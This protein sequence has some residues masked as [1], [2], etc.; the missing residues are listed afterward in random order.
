MTCA[1][2]LKVPDKISDIYTYKSL[3]A[4]L[5]LGRGECATGSDGRHR[6][7]NNAARGELCLSNIL[8]T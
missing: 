7:G 8:I 4:C 3:T 1:V 2:V 6:N 5:S